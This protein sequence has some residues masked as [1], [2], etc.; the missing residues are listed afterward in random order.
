MKYMVSS[1]EQPQNYPFY[2]VHSDMDSFILSN[3]D[4]GID[5]NT[6]LKQKHKEVDSDN[7]FHESMWHFEFDGSVNRLGAGAGVWIHNM[8]NNH[9]EGH[10]FRLNFKCTNNMAEYEALILELQI[11]RNLGGKRVSIMGYSDLIVKQIRGEYSMY[12]PRLSQ[13]R[14]IFLDLIKELLECDFAIIPRK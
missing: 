3:Y 10:A 4:S 14:E 7:I 5:K 8:E 6:A 12:N 1:T 9:L 13:Y 11:V 2:S